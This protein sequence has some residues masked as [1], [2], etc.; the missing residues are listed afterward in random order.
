VS[1]K[2]NIKSKK[3]AREVLIL[4][5]G[6]NSTFFRRCVVSAYGQSGYVPGRTVH[7]DLNNDTD[8]PHLSYA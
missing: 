6:L 5:T 1:G 7:C 4:R 2:I 8:I 3:S